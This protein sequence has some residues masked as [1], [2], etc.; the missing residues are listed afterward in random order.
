MNLQLPSIYNPVP[1]RTILLVTVALFLTGCGR[2]PASSS[3]DG[4]KNPDAGRKAG[5][6][7]P[8][9]ASASGP[10]VTELGVPLYPGATKVPT[11][12]LVMTDGSKTSA[13]SLVTDDDVATVAEFYRTEG[14]KVG[15]IVDTPMNDSSETLK[16]VP[17]ALND[18]RRCQIQVIKGKDGK[19]Q[20]HIL[21]F[22]RK[23]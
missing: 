18:G 6:S 7:K 5:A 3:S 9:D 1:M 10:E 8:A 19:T 13:E 11:S 21:T 20:I 17:I 2:G 23:T 15:K 12:D 14:A 4:A 22:N 16:V